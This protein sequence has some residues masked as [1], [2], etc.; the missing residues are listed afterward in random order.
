M[1]NIIIFA[2]IISIISCK[3]T[4]KEQNPINFKQQDLGL[5][6]DTKTY[7]NIEQQLNW[8]AKSL[9]II[10]NN[11]I[12]FKSSMHNMIN[13]TPFKEKYNYDTQ[14]EFLLTGFNYK[15]TVINTIDNININNGFDT[16][17][18]FGFSFLDCVSNT[19]VKFIDAE[20]GNQVNS[21]ML[22]ATTVYETSKDS[23]IGYFYNNI[24]NNLDSLILTNDNYDNY[25]IW[26]V[27]AN[28]MCLEGINSFTYN[29]EGHCGNG[30]C[31]PFLDENFSNCIDCPNPP[32]QS[33]T[34]TLEYIKPQFDQKLD[35]NGNF[36]PIDVTFIDKG[37]HE[38]YFN[39]KY[40]I[41][42]SYLISRHDINDIDIFT[43][44]DRFFLEKIDRRLGRDVYQDCF[45]GKTKKWNEL[46]IARLKARK[47]EIVREA[48]KNGIL[49]RS[50]NASQASKKDI[51][52][53]LSFDYNPITDRVHINLNEWD[54]AASIKSNNTLSPQQSALPL[55]P[56]KY[57]YKQTGGH[58]NGPWNYK[59]V[60]F[61]YGFLLCALDFVPFQ[62]QIP[63]HWVPSPGLYG[64]NSYYYD[65]NDNVNSNS[66][67]FSDYRLDVNANRDMEKSEMTIRL[68]IRKNP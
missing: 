56:W 12:S 52:K 19:T 30:K 24:S 10:A 39:G 47:N 64:P 17:L 33:Y 32:S 4:S 28:N 49:V 14:R 60:P 13:L 65:I 54:V 21:K 50:N 2:I 44:E 68:V 37:Y 41:F 57:F 51:K 1:K 35:P 40:D 22:V 48:E 18:F 31:E 8:I 15:N 7:E 63:V 59:H 29:P 16:S 9:P 43:I 38:S 66:N 27:D 55:V 46:M 61:Y 3:R 58:L 23:F 25:Y 26:I 67:L 42:F 34:L 20:N 11:I 36:P 6:P 62:N 53:I 5:V 45:G